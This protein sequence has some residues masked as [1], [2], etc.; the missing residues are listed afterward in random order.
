MIGPRTLALAVGALWMLFGLAP[1]AH[2]ASVGIPIECASPGLCVGTDAAETS[3][4]APYF[5]PTRLVVFDPRTNAA[6]ATRSADAGL[7][8]GD[9]ECFSEAR[10]FAML[11]SKTGTIDSPAYGA[12]FDPRSSGP[13]TPVEIPGANLASSL[14]CP[15]P[16]QCTM[17]YSTYDPPPRGPDGVPLSSGAAN[18]LWQ[19]TF[20]PAN[21][22]AATRTKLQERSAPGAILIAGQL[23]CASTARCVAIANLNEGRV[24]SFD[25]GASSP[26]TTATLPGLTL[27]GL[28]CPRADACIVT[29]KPT[30]SVNADERPQG[31]VRRFAP[32]DPSQ[33]TATVT[34]PHW[35]DEVRCP[36]GRCYAKTIGKG[37]I[38][39]LLTIDV[40]QLSQDTPSLRVLH[41]PALTADWACPLADRCWLGVYGWY[42]TVATFNPLTGAGAPRR[43][44]FTPASLTV[45]SRQRV[46]LSPRFEVPVVGAPIRARLFRGTK[47]VDKGTFTTGLNRT[48][49]W[50]IGRLKPGRYVA[51]FEFAPE[52]L[53]RGLQQRDD[54]IAI[55]VKRP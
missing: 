39:G 11:F 52:A 32:A 31:F 46:S 23:Q 33:A 44:G 8:V 43:P 48:I 27:R 37:Y 3:M 29:G 5:D 42:T 40:A 10:C 9:V 17:T 41:S 18:A 47:V 6:V 15:S 19:T 20:D 38:G 50:K 30:A 1:A 49:V 34:T 4:E 12:V 35:V 14:D 21:P 45:T 55:R 22:A 26:V 2:A 51:D 28:A 16:V 54:Q 25:P 36:A 7:A 24:I 13:L 53:A